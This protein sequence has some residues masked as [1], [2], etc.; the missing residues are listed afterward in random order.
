MHLKGKSFSN[1]KAFF[2]VRANKI[3]IWL[4]EGRVYLKTENYLLGVGSRSLRTNNSSEGGQPEI[5]NKL[6]YQNNQRLALAEIN[7]SSLYPIARIK[8]A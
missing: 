3:L 7:N 2:F 4:A 5:K 6:I 8:L 1:L